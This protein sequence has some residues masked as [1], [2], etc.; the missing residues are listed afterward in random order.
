MQP[1]K[2]LLQVVVNDVLLRRNQIMAAPGNDEAGA[3]AEHVPRSGHDVRA[4]YVARLRVL[5]RRLRQPRARTAR[6]RQLLRQ[7]RGRQLRGV[8]SRGA[9]SS[10][11]ACGRPSAQ[12]QAQYRQQFRTAT[13]PSPPA[14]PTTSRA[15]PPYH[16]PE[17]Q[18]VAP[19]QACPVLSCML[20]ARWHC[21]TG[22][23]GKLHHLPQSCA[24]CAHGGL[25]H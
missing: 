15:Q 14:V 18:P 3:R 20:N 2:Q 4:D 12:A 1:Y 6:R 21:C 11:C 17:Q 9:A 5:G 22:L 8:Q 23:A 7:L 13:P 10:I 16:T 19:M 24:W 25:V